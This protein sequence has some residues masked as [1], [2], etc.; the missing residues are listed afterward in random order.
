MASAV[1]VVLARED[2]SIPG[3]AEGPGPAANGLSTKAEFFGLVS[4][5][6]PDVIVLDLSR[7]PENGAATIATVRQQSNVPILVACAP[8]LSLVE[9]YRDAGA[10]DFIA[11]PIDLV[12]LNQSIQKVLR[13]RAQP[14]SASTP[15][16][17]EYCFDGLGFHVG[18]N[19]LTTLSG[20]EIE[21]SSA[22]G[23]LLGHFV[24]KPWSFC[25]RRELA[26]LFLGN[27]ERVPER[28][29]DI[30]VSGLRKKLGSAGIADAERLIRREPHR[31]Y[32][33]AAD[34][35]AAAA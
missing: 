31:G 13:M 14:G 1:N 22:E 19:V 23:R 11:A 28:A 33:L 4:H 16:P 6:R 3:S 29:I 9:E 20:S 26:S 7:A 2:L 35:R 25:T 24:K 34:V 10:T 8:V 12:R 21:L 30:N 5:S 17:K 32:L 15:G 18:H 27:E